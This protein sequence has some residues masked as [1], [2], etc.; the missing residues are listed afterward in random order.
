MIMEKTSLEKKFN[1]IEDVAPGKILKFTNS[2]IQDLNN[3]IA[4]YPYSEGILPQVK[5]TAPL[6]YTV[7]CVP[8]ARDYYNVG[9][10]WFFNLTSLNTEYTFYT[11]T[12]NTTPHINKITPVE[13]RQYS[14][15]VE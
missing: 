10:Q 4:V 1:R 7:T 11:G 12:P 6:G 15:S 13:Y 5:V 2:D 14:I 3:I 9:N 8:S